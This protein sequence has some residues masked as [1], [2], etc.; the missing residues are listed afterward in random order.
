MRNYAKFPISMVMLSLIA[1]TP[2]HAAQALKVDSG[3][4]AWMLLSTALVMLMTPGL[5][6]FYGGLVRRKNVLSIF[7]YCFA[8]LAVA[9]IQWVTIGYSEVFGPSIGGFIG[10]MDHAFLRGVGQTPSAHYASTVPQIIFV[11]YQMMFAVITPGLIAGAVAERMK[12]SAFLV[13]CFMWNT[14]VYAP[15]AHWMWNVDGWLAKQGA[16]DF[17]GGIVVHITSGVSAL[18]AAYIVGKRHGYGKESFFPNNLT[19][20][21]TGGALLWFGWFGFNG[22]SALTSGGLACNAFMVTHIAASC[23]CVSWITIEWIQRQKPSAL[24]AVSG[25]VAG[26]AGITPVSG[27]VSPM[28]AM[29]IGTILGLVCYLAV[30][31]KVKLGYDDALDAFGVHGIGGATGALMAG[32]FATS[33]VNPAVVHLG[34]AMGGNSSLLLSQLQAVVVTIVYA[35]GVTAIILSLLKL[36]T[37]LRVNDSDEREGLD[38]TQHGELGYH[39]LHEE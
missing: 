25:A 27:Y 18:V 23:A 9:T 16:I 24:G 2:A 10:N 13:F 30:N 32:V 31:A 21:L 20:C 8:A 15:V 29:L 4:T 28:A 38:I 39:M 36:T 12:F 33:A 17:A 22:G 1:A 3:D 37:G 14:V 11:A 19:M 34:L 6:L 5:A 7:M 26:L 35:A